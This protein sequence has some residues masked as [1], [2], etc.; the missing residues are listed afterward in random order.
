[1]RIQHHPVVVGIVTEIVPI[2]TSD[3]CV[4]DCNHNFRID[5]TNC[6]VR[7]AVKLAKS[8]QTVVVIVPN[9]GLIQQLNDRYGV[10]PFGGVRPLGGTAQDFGRATKVVVVVVKINSARLTRVVISIL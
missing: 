4:V 6:V 1:M 9:H 5:R 7:H 10:T 3:K 8:I 2:F